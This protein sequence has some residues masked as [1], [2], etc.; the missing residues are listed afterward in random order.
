MPPDSQSS[1]RTWLLSATIF[2]GTLIYAENFDNAVES[3][4]LV[5][6]LIGLSLYTGFLGLSLM[7]PGRQLRLD[8]YRAL[9]LSFLA[10][11][12]ILVLASSIYGFTAYFAWNQLPLYLC[13]G[14]VFL[15]G[16]LGLVSRKEV[17]HF[18]RAFVYAALINSLVGLYQYFFGPI[19]GIREVAPPAGL[20]GNRNFS[21]EIALS[22]TPLCLWIYL[23][24]KRY[25]AKF[26][27][28][29]ALGTLLGFII[30]CFARATVL[31]AIIILPLLILAV[32]RA[33]KS[34]AENTPSAKYYLP[35]FIS[36]TVAVLL[37]LLPAHEGENRRNIVKQK[38]SLIEK[39]RGADGFS[40]MIQVD[41]SAH[42]RWALW[43]NSIHAWLERP[44][45]GH[46]F[47]TWRSVYHGYAQLKVPDRSIRRGKDAHH[48]HN[49]YIEILV[50]T[51][52]VGASLALAFLSILL[53]PA[54]GK[55][56]LTKQGATPSVRQPLFFSS[57]L[58]ILMT[59]FFSMPLELPV[60]PFVLAVLLA[61]MISS[62]FPLKDD[63]TCRQLPRAASIAIGLIICASSVYSLYRANQIRIVEIKAEQLDHLFHAKKFEA[64]KQLSR[65]ILAIDPHHQTVNNRLAIIA[66]DHDLDSSLDYMK[67][68]EAVY[69]N[70]PTN[71]AF[72]A[73]YYTRKG[74][75][76]LALNYWRRLLKVVPSDEMGLREASQLAYEFGHLDESV[77]YL[78]KLVELNPENQVY[79]K[80]LTNLKRRLS[81]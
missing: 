23:S 11:G 65:D 8:R 29:I 14:T 37:P 53:L 68:I 74:N 17:E 28:A 1:G 67:N 77:K 69:P 42:G 71:S 63:E 3:P 34:D 57:A 73:A 72:L 6:L 76:D 21:S 43:V 31:A 52:I 46:G 4:K 36:L 56:I 61:S 50:E 48:A 40:E 18:I 10:V 39:Y 35:L 16:S 25:I 51:G 54:A 80:S 24:T 27:W 45:F 58:S 13:A 47:G 26:V 22:A 5:V 38:I 62:T 15:V 44:V 2:L 60:L 66:F 32:I 12:T 59:A 33:R 81:H 41:G 9:V 70:R 79:L 55:I 7:A 30:I 49:F 75:K 64:V 19:D 20:F 78:E